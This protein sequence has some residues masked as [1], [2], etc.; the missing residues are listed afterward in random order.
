MSA[1]QAAEIPDRLSAYQL[2][3]VFFM[4]Q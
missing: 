1:K 3:L 4:L 2:H